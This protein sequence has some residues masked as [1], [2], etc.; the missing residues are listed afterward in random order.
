MS[1]S[2]SKASGLLHSSSSYP[3][4]A[5]GQGSKKSTSFL[6]FVICS[7][8]LTALHFGY[9]IANINVAQNVFT[10]CSDFT[11]NDKSPSF[12]VFG[13]EGCFVISKS[14]YGLVGAGVPVG[15]WIGSLTGGSIVNTF[16]M[17]KSILLLNIP[18]VFGYLLM[19]FSS[20]IWMLIAGRLFQGFV[21]GIS[22]VAVPSYISAVTPEALRGS[23]V[24]FFQLFLVSGVLIAELVS[25]GG[26]LGHHLWRWRFGFGAGLIVCLA[27]AVLFALGYLPKSPIELEESGQIDSARQMRL[28][29][30]FEAAETSN[31]KDS[32]SD[33]DLPKEAERQDDSAD[34]MSKLLS[35]KIAKA[36]KSLLLGFLLHAGQQL[37]GVNSVFF[38]STLIFAGDKSN[39]SSGDTS[40][41][42]IPI[43]LATVNL[44][45]TFLA[46]FLLK[47]AGRRLIALLSSSGS[48]L[49]L[50]LL[51]FCMRVY[52]KIS[53]LPA[54]GFIILF[55]VGLGPIP[56]LIM[57]EIFPP[58]WSLTIPAISA[59][60]SAN[61]IVNILVTGIFPFAADRLKDRKELIFG[62]FGLCSSFVFI[63]LCFLMPETRNRLSNFI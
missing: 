12:G 47:K 13:L 22:G 27:Q 44:L 56:W 7:A 31:L 14:F 29:L 34:S 41:S 23:F 25:Y 20:N 38:Y 15:G 57:P 16:G 3:L 33:H 8:A 63:A 9:V 4:T 52:P 42:L 59:C 1:S 39:S 17:Q 32:S 45:S 37:S 43:V 53:V 10:K 46:I 62:F 54:I 11:L 61:W 40:Q 24:N 49:S 30:G 26:D 51:A 6:L 28:R 55:A 35:F 58:K 50:F 5:P 21:C 18:L 48:A 19:A 2:S 36:N 60:I